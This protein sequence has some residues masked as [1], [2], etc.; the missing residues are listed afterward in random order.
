MKIYL[1]NSLTYAPEE[2][3]RSINELKTRLKEKYEVLDWLG[4]EKGTPQDVY[5]HD[6][7]CVQNCDLLVAECSYPAIGLGFEIGTSLCINKPVLAIAKEEAKVTRL[8]LGITHPLFEFVRYKTTE[9]ILQA[10]EEKIKA[11]KYV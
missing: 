3:K 9:E 11:I 10:V 2:F 6:L 1:A 5:N 7:S 8:I 4:L